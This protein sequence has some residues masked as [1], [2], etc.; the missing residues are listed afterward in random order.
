M[1]KTL[2]KKIQGKYIVTKETLSKMKKK[3]IL[4]HCLPRVGEI[5]T[6]VDDDPR[7]VYLRSQVQNGM[8]IRMALLALVL[9][10][11]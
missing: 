9:G 2:Y 8:Y 5:A 10:K 4:M 7:A 1:S 11:V 3:S 6:E